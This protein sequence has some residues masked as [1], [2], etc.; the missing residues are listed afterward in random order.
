GVRS[1]RVRLQLDTRGVLWWRNESSRLGEQQRDLIEDAFN[2][3]V[4]SAA[5]IWEIAIKSR[6]GK[7]QVP[8]DLLMQLDVREVD[9]LDI[10]AD[11][12]YSVRDLPLHHRDPFDRLIVTHAR[13]EGYPTVTSSVWPGVYSGPI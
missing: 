3:V 10:R 4:V 9:V 2:E 6:I 8:D 12:A 1:E 5:S 7:L 13:A 11:H